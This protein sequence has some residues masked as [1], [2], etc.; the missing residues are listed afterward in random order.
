MRPEVLARLAGLE[1]RHAELARALADPAIFGDPAR[2][3]QI[4]RE[5]AGLAQV[6]AAFQDHQRLAQELEDA[7]ALSR[8]ADPELR[9][10][11]AAEK[12]SL[13]ER[14]AVLE[15]SIEESLLPRDPRDARNSGS[16]SRERASASSSSRASRRYSWKTATTCDKPACSRVTCA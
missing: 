10:L 12:A 1:A 6:V 16:A 14:Q 3:A 2:Y 8:E 5:H 7:E 4:G 9:A 13:A 15:R 11:A